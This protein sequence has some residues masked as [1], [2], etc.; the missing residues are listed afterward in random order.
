MQGWPPFGH[1]ASV[2]VSLRPYQD[3]QAKALPYPDTP[4]F[5]PQYSNTPADMLVITS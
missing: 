3:T 5:L 1:H 2:A 4:A